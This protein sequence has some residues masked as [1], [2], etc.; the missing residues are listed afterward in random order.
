MRARHVRA[1]HH[2]RRDALSAGHLQVLARL[3]MVGPMPVSR[4]AATLGVSAAAA[5]GMIG[6]MEDRGLVRRA[7]D[8]SDRRV[9]LVRLTAKGRTVLADIDNRGRASLARVLARLDAEELAQL[10]NGLRALQRAMEELA[11]EEA[12]GERTR[13]SGTACGDARPRPDRGTATGLED[14]DAPE[15][16]H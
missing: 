14:A 11:D 1:G 4:V 16:P 7:R 15:D 6:R 10:R 12:V 9:V 2:D 13:A 8:E 3:H 5:T